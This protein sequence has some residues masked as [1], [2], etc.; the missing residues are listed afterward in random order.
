MFL[1]ARQ[2]MSIVLS[3]LSYIV[4]YCVLI[5][6]S[7]SWEGHSNEARDSLQEKSL[8]ACN[9]VGTMYTMSS[10]QQSLMILTTFVDY[11]SFNLTS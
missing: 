10:D 9:Q 4:Y 6:L 5:A 8:P 2:R 1:F 7:S 11:C 3:C